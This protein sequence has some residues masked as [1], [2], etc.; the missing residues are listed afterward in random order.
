[1]CISYLMNQEVCDIRFYC[2]KHLIGFP[3]G[4]FYTVITT[5]WYE[6]SNNK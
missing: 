5:L 3:S 1:M 4:L 2:E 6:V